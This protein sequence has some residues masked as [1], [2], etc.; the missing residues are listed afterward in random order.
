MPIKDLRPA[1]FAGHIGVRQ[2][3]AG[4]CHEAGIWCCGVGTGAAS[5]SFGVGRRDHGNGQGLSDVEES[6][7]EAAVVKGF[8]QLSF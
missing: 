6:P 8:F 1:E 3:P 5:L 7:Q 4:P 2:L